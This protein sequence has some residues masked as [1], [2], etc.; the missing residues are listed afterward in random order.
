[1]PCLS[2]S[3]PSVSCSSHF[4]SRSSAVLS[5][6]GSSLWDSKEGD[7]EDEEDYEEEDADD[8]DENSEQS[9]ML[10]TPYLDGDD[11]MTQSFAVDDSGALQL[12]NFVHITRDGIKNM[13]M[14]Y[15][16]E[17][18][19]MGGGGVKWGG[20]YMEGMEMRGGAACGAVC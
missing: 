15:V 18:V 3:Y 8:F 2:P 13:Q 7:S 10:G 4:F 1:M 6:A 20:Q 11:P 12:R 17:G 16:K 5:V 19:E 14:Q 9:S